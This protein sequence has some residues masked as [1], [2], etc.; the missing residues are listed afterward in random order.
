MRSLTRIGGFALLV[1]GALLAR[2]DVALSQAAAPLE[3]SWSGGGTVTFSTGSRERA[4]CRA[5]YAKASAVSYTMNAVCATPSGRAA[6]TATLRKV[7]ENSYQGQFFNAEY[8]I[9]GAIYVVVRGN[10]QSVRLSSSSGS[11]NFNL[12]R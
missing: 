2:G 9:S 8:G 11:G 7:G 1:A 4:S 3:G 10:H 5:R 12:S 6:Q